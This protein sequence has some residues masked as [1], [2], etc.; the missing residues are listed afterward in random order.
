MSDK[1]QY[2]AGQNFYLS[3]NGVS[4]SDATITLRSF[5][6]PN[7]GDTIVMADFGDIGYG[8]FEPGTSRREFFSFTG[9]TQNVDGSAAL[10]GVTRG[11]DAAAPYTN[12]PA[13]QKGHG[14]NTLVR[15]TNSPQFYNKLAGRDNDE[16]IN[17]SWTFDAD[18]YPKVDDAAKPPVADAEF[19]TKKYADDLAI[20]GSPD[21]TTAVKGIVEVATAAEAAANTPAGGG[22]TSASLAVTTAITSNTSGAA[23]VIPVTDADGDIPVEFMELD[24]QWD[25]TGDVNHSGTVNFTGE[26]DVTP[27]TNFS[28]G[29]VNY[30]GTMANMNTMEANIDT[31]TDGSDASDLHNHAKTSLGAVAAARYRIPFD[32]GSNAWNTSDATLSSVSNN[33]AFTLQSSNDTWATLLVLPGDAAND[34]ILY[35]QGKDLNFDICVKPTSGTTGDRRF[36]FGTT[37]PVSFHSAYNLSSQSFVGFGS[38]GGTLYAI[39]CDG[40][41][42]TTVDVSASLTYTDWNTFRVEFESGTEARY[43]INNSLVTTINTNLPSNNVNVTFGAGGQTNGEDI[44]M[45]NPI[46]DIEL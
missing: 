32:L 25:F 12:V 15:I 22:D 7:S 4:A 18:A 23:Q 37:T 39:S 14:G 29:G 24:A 11:L 38:D 5:T 36:G 45:L 30:T 40:S 43:Y 27:A 19:A 6:F 44:T 31:L 13:L 1:F 20:A 42:V 8:V 34:R 2:V 35:N 26:L 9:V 17:G 46:L 10:T 28:L 16:T 33:M 21:A 3:G 41:N